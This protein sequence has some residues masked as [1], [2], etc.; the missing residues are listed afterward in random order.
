MSLPSLLLAVVLAPPSPSP[1][2]PTP[3]P[4]TREAEPPAEAGPAEPHASGA[5]AV[6]PEAALRQRA[7][8]VRALMAGTLGVDVDADALFVLD[9]EQP[10]WQGQRTWVELLER[11]TQVAEAPAEA[12]AAERPARPPKGR[13]EPKPAAE[14]PAAEVPPSARDDLLDA[15]ATFLAQPAQV[16]ADQLEHHRA[17]QRAALTEREADARRLAQAAALDEAAA[18]IE[19]L[20]ARRFDPDVDPRTLLSRSLLGDASPLSDPRRRAR[21]LALATEAPPAQ[22]DPA[23]T[24]EPA[25]HEDGSE[26]DQ[27]PSPS[28][29]LARAEARYEAAWAALV[30]LGP[31]GRAA[32]L[33]A[34]ED[35]L[36]PAPGV[37]AEPAITEVSEEP[38]PSEA[39]LAIDEAEQRAAAAAEE[40]ELALAAAQAARSESLRL[41][42]EERAALLAIKEAQARF[43]GDLERQRAS[44][45]H[46]HEDALAWQR[47][48][49]E[50]AA[51][52]GDPSTAADA[53]Y[54]P[55]RQQLTVARDDLRAALARLG[56]IG[57]DVPSPASVPRSSSAE[58]TEEL[59]QL[60]AELEAATVAMRSDALDVAWLVATSVRDDTVAMNRAR[61]RLLELASP[62]LRGAVTGLGAPGLDQVR[63]ELDQI[64]LELRYHARAW[65]RIARAQVA[66]AARRPLAMVLDAL[67]LF[68]LLTGFFAWRRIADGLLAR[69][70]TRMLQRG[71]DT[72]SRSITSSLLY[73][74]RR[75]RS[76]VEWTLLIVVGAWTIAGLGELPELRILW[77]VVF[78]GLVGWTAVL[79]LD[80]VAARYHVQ[81]SGTDTSSLRLES[82]R[83]VV[84]SVVV[85]ALLLSLTELL[86]GAGAIYAWVLRFCWFLALPIGL[87]L[88]HRWRAVVLERAQARA[89]KD[90][91]AATIASTRTG[92]RSYVA[93]TVGGLYLLGLGLGRW[94]ARWLQGIEL[95]RRLLAY[96]FRRTVTRQAR[97]DET[98][99]ADPLPATAYAALGPDG[100]ASVLFDD[101][102]DE[103][104]A[105]LVE[106]LEQRQAALVAIVG[107]R[108]LGKSS[109]L[110]HLHA[111]AEP[112]D[113]MVITVPPT[114]PRN[115]L[116]LLG[117]AIGCAP[118]PDALRLAL[119]RREHTRVLVDDAHRLFRPAIDG[120]RGFDEFV[121]FIRSVGPSTDWVL[122]FEAAAWQY[123]Q[124]ARGERIVFDRVILLPRWS[125]TELE[126]LTTARTRQLGLTASF[127]RFAAGG[128]PG[129]EVTA[130]DVERSE[131]G[132]H[133]MLWDSANGNPGAALELWRRSL[134]LRDDPAAPSVH[135]FR[136][137]PA[138]PIEQLPL[139]ALFVLRTVVQLDV[140]SP[141]DV[142][143]CTQLLLSEVREH[144]SHGLARGYLEAVDGGARL[145]WYWYP[146]IMR[147]LTRQHLLEA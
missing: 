123:L 8:D 79:A 93:G 34:R 54:E 61:L 68:V 7:A 60:R 3:A 95:T 70:R 86:V 47:R 98:E 92:W 80:A 24:D 140:A 81:G 76:P 84:Y 122:S 39:T 120:L 100:P 26:P 29:V 139:D 38:P 19:S 134:W 94:L 104:R 53:A 114:A 111:H 62:E 27:P 46:L 66:K 147:V 28:L 90:R 129:R 17:L 40:R 72:T 15:L 107:E 30:E 91:F 16:R 49:D 144:L 44:A 51:A 108:G 96:A 5:P 31:E 21:A 136:E 74:V 82:L 64:G 133:R 23:A 35:A 65:P 143:L 128:V 48:L 103:A 22:A 58:R 78:W 137:A 85:V 55:L 2:P 126:E 36:A 6:P 10:P 117:A 101:R 75:I 18:R 73:Y 141:D 63:R 12:E 138:E 127:T 124:R 113:T 42:A 102:W 57:S 109:L 77:L 106:V 121:A 45:E 52:P 13:H 146:T 59:E 9:L 115:P 14:A 116:V 50:L 20:L 145:S 32:L 25:P 130:E 88:V 41:V 97:H 105:A 56:D 69:A 83:L 112:S 1:A 110:G 43:M 67:Q 142:A 87:R 132:F 119:A 33:R 37:A 118:E 99:V 4:A 125:E 11:T 131:R 89:S 135:L 71:I